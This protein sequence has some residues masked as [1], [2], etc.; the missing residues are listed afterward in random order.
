MKNLF[1]AAAI[2][3][4]L[5]TGPVAAAGPVEVRS[6][7]VT[8]DSR[9]VMM[10]TARDYNL[11]LGFVQADGSFLAN[12]DVSIQDAK[13]ATVWSGMADGPLLFAR[14]PPGSY[15]VTA[16]TGGQTLKRSVQTAEGGPITYLRW[17]A[18]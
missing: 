16:T 1:F 18:R 13:G 11:H 7:G 14:L 10:K 3:A 2:A 17:P 15:T 9:D 5:V 4:A 12:I 6:D 8:K